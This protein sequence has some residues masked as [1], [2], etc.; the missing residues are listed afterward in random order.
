LRNRAVLLS[1]VFLAYICSA[2]LAVDL[3]P[4]KF[5]TV[6]KI[7][8]GMKGIGKTV[9]SGTKVEEFQIEVL[10]VDKNYIGPKSDIIWVQCS[11]GPL[12]ETNVMQGM[13][14]SPIYIDGKLIGA[15]A[16]VAGSFIKRPIAG[17]TPISD[18]LGIIENDKKGGS[19]GTGTMS[20]SEIPFPIPGQLEEN[21]DNETLKT[22]GI[23]ENASSGFEKI[24]N[25]VMLS[26]FSSRAIEYL[27][28]M[29]KKYGMVAVQGG[30]MSSQS[31]SEDVKL[32][33]GA[34]IGVQFVRG[35]SSAYASGTVTYVDGNKIL[36]FGHSMVGMGPTNMP[37]ALGR[38]TI[39]LP[40]LNISSKPASPVRTIGTMTQDTQ[41]GI[42]IDTEKQPEFIP[43]R[44]KV[45]SQDNSQ[46]QEFNFEVLKN[47]LFAPSYI[48][49][50]ALDAIIFSTKEEGDYTMKTHSE[51]SIKGYPKLVRDN[52]FSG[53]SMDIVATDFAVPINQIMRNRFEEVDIDNIL[54]EISFENKRTNALIDD[55]RINKS[56]VKPGDSFVIKVS[57]TPYMQDT[58]IK[59]FGITI[60][61]D[62]PEGRALLRISDSTSS[63][64]WEKSRVPMKSG[65]ESVSQIISQIQKEERNNNIIVELFTSKTGMTVRGEELPALPLTALSVIGSSKQTGISEPTLGTTFLKQRIE[66]DYVLTG[67]AVLLLIIDQDA[68]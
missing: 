46:V 61:K 1:I 50:A 53:M 33:P 44:V 3:D 58:I 26:G 66:T 36:A 59:E 10:N 40:S 29:L 16:Y 54:L 4:N 32:E 38:V 21:G 39:L 8:P 30:G 14:G 43:V 35:D 48:L 22:F 23:S 57:I 42:L 64:A 56:M 7:K 49:A 51:V 62:M 15:I 41:Y 37:V 12:E 55:V 63:E 20:E 11:G 68:P 60:P 19:I 45:K 2:V 25:P 9:F 65:P 34:V 31:D 28:P 24:Q 6:D 47:K 18:M 17:V 67:N 13:S 52:I 5:M 27:N